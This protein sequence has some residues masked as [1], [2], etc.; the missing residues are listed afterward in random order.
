[1]CIS[2]SQATFVSGHQITDNLIIAHEY[3]HWLNHRRKG[4]DAYMA[5]KIDISKAYDRVKSNFL[6]EVMNK[7]V[8]CPLWLKWIRGC[9]SSLSFSFNV[10]RGKFGYVCPSRGI[11]QGDL[12]SPYFFLFC[13]EHLSSLGGLKYPEMVPL[14]HFSF[15]LMIFFYFA[16]QMQ[17]KQVKS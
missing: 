9:L 15:F 14:Y 17:K 16:K 13:V 8:F 7:M 3:I 1:M 11:R 6:L 5:L 10:N 4:K 2:K 12:L